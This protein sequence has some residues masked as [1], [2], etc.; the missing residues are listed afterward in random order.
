[1]TIVSENLGGHGPFVPPD[2]A[3]GREPGSKPLS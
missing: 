2:Y 3:Y 1:M